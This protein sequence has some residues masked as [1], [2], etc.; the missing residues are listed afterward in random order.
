[1]AW[2]I[3]LTE[4]GCYRAEGTHGWDDGY[5]MRWETSFVGYGR[6]VEAAIADARR[7]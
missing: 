1:M 5:G 2:F 3:S 7:G 4:N 6:T